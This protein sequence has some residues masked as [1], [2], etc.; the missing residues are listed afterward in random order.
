MSHETDE[1]RGTRDEN[2]RPTVGV[3]VVSTTLG[4]TDLYRVRGSQ[5]QA[6]RNAC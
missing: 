2:R 1:A 4:D 5:I 6:P 3:D